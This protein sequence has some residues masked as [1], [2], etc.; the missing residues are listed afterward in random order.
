[1]LRKGLKRSARGRVAILRKLCCAAQRAGVCK[2]LQV[3]SQWVDG[4][5]S[6]LISD[7]TEGKIAGQ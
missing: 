7:V 3:H 4:T 5:V 2:G 6:I 1:M